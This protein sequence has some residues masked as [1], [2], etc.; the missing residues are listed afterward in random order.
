M[1]GRMKTIGLV[2]IA[3]L[4]LP[5]CGRRSDLVL[6]S[7]GDKI[8]SESVIDA[9]RRETGLDVITASDTEVSRGVALRTRILSEMR[10]PR[11]D[12]YWNNEIANTL[13]LKQKGALAPYKSPSAEGIPAPWADPEGY[14][15]A[16]GARA[17]IFLVNTD[18]VPKGEEPTSMYDM[19]DPRWKGRVGMSRITGGTTATHASALFELLGEDKTRQFFRDLK[20]NGVVLCNGNGHVKDMVAQGELAWG[21]TDTNDANVAIRYGRPVK[22]VYPDQGEGQIGTLLIPHTVALIKGGPHPEAARRFID[23]LLRKETEQQLAASVSVQIPLRDG[24]PVPEEARRHFRMDVAS[25]RNFN[26]RIDFARVAERLPLVI[27]CLEKEF[28]R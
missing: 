25:I 14:W 4:L 23:F 10:K 2:V 20:A 27:A 28:N 15:T 11:A 5:A 8:F 24:V 17:R 22:V 18:L 19:L 21:W 26:D 1:E 6:Y 9:F 16:F 3:T 12:V 7:A 13:L